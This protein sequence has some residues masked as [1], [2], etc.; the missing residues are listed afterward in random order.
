MSVN[1]APP[2]SHGAGSISDKDAVAAPGNPFISCSASGWRAPSG[3]F[4]WRARRVEE[5]HVDGFRFD[6]ASVLCRGIDGAP[7]IAP[8]FIKERVML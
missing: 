2:S 1:P 8:P 7:L 3:C 4:S 6:V 5:Y